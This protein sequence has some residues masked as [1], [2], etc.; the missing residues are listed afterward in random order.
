MS[1]KDHIKN[2]DKNHKLQ[3]KKR[4]K[5]FCYKNIKEPHKNP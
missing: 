4:K 1:I 3:S 2:L 5:L